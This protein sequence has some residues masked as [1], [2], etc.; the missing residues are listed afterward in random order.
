MGLGVIV[1]LIYTPIMIRTLGNSEYGLYNTVASTISIL[2][3]LTLGFNSSYI[4]F[5]SSYK[6]NNDD[7]KIKKLNGLFL[8]IFL[9]IGC[10]ALLCGLFLSFNLHFVFK[11]GLTATEYD[12][13]FELMILLTINLAISFPMSVFGN[14]ISAH[15]KFLFLKL[16]SIIKTVLSPL[17]I[18]PLLLLGYGSVMIVVITI[19]ISLF[20][21]VMYLFY[22]FCILRIK[23]CFHG[24][25]KNLFKELL[26]FTSFIAINLIVDQINLNIDKVLLGRFKGTEAVAIYSVGFTLYTYFQM[27]SNS[28]V[29]LFTPRIHH[30]VNTYSG[31]QQRDELTTLF[32]KVGRIQFLIISLVCTG[33][34]FFGMFFITELWADYGYSDSYFVMLLLCVPSIVPLTQNLG[35]EIQRAQN[36]HKFRSVVYLLMAITNLVLSIF[37]C[38]KYGPI[39]C[40]VGTAISLLVANCLIM[41]IYYHKKCNINIYSYWKNI[42]RMSA[43]L[44]FP[45][46]F[47]F[48]I[49]FVF[50]I[51]TTVGFFMGIFAYTLIYILSMWL[52]SMNQYEKEFFL[53][54][55][56]RIFKTAR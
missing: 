9:L 43:G 39:G 17:L 56:K 28:L 18:I 30:I 48:L 49:F 10:V 50:P 23:F 3:L 44:I 26:I 22:C 41:N 16:L 25:E 53:K 6:K 31:K 11:D 45:L 4:K 8:I 12:T 34:V 20:V 5:F 54:P 24:F 47:G 19:I 42:I 33:F 14:I 37:L 52:I 38:Q 27:F 40:A 7:I 36:N 29:S 1:S 55:L 21:D 51:K 46:A 35:I 13:A 15:E 2:S 32:V